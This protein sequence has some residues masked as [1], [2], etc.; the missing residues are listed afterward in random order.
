VRRHRELSSSKLDLVENFVKNFK[1]Q[2]GKYEKHPV[3]DSRI[4]DQLSGSEV[5]MMKREKA[6]SANGFYM[7]VLESNIMLHRH[8]A[9]RGHKLL[10][11]WCRRNWRNAPIKILDLA[12][13]G[14]PYSIVRMMGACNQ[15]K[16]SYTGIDINPDQI[17][18]AKASWFPDNVVETRL[19]EGNAWDLSML[20]ADEKFDIIFTGMNTHHGTPEEIYCLLLQVK[21]RLA[22]GGI[23][24][25]H[26]L[27]RP[28]GTPHL[29][30]PD[31]NPDDPGESFAMVAHETL[32]KYHASELASP[33]KAEPN[34]RDWRERFLTKYK[35]ALQERGAHEEGIREVV[36]HVSRRDYPISTK[37]LEAI[38]EQAGFVLSVLDMEAS[39]EPLEA[40]F[41]LVCAQPS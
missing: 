8:A 1:K 29:P 6:F 30:R 4:R 17:E 25:N 39:G 36:E 33:I 34:P 23:Y 40:Y 9:A 27:F 21:E 22:P 26:D 13:G 10:S 19:I 37:D 41:S 38:A 2:G 11:D 18:A 28:A 15:Y 35:L 31:V 14:T 3:A 24:I 5:P 7:F 20:P 16:F 12:C 32:A